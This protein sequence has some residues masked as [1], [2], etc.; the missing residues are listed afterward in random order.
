MRSQ[1]DFKDVYKLNKFSSG[2]D[3]DWKPFMFDLLGFDGYLLS[4]KYETDAK[5]EEIKVLIKGLQNE[6][7]VK[8]KDRD[9]IVAERSIFE[10]KYKELE[11]QV[12][13]FNFYNQ[14]KELINEVITELEEKISAFNSDSYTLNY[15]IEKL[16]ESNC[17]SFVKY[18]YKLA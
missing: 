5:I 13:R 4:M 11:E 10:E 1:D 2:K 17:S 6:Y 14:D 7:L 12:D 18:L 8:T 16:R 3:V 9:E 15:E